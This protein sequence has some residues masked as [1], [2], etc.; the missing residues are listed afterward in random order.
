MRSSLDDIADELFHGGKAKPEPLGEKKTRGEK[1]EKGESQGK[2][3]DYRKNPGANE[4]RKRANSPLEWAKGE[5]SPPAYPIEALGPLAGVAHVIAEKGQI[6]PAMAGQCVLTAA[7][8]CVQGLKEVR[9]L[10]GSKPLSLY[11]ATI[12]DSGD[13]KSFAEGIALGGIRKLE[14]K[15]HL[16]YKASVEKDMKGKGSK[17]AASG[18]ELPP[19]YILMKNATAQGIWRSFRDG[20]ASQGSFT[21]E[22]AV[23]L[24]GWGM[25]AEQ[26]AHTAGSVNDLWDGGAISIQRG[27]EGRTQ[28]YG[29]RFTVH[30]LIQPD[31]VSESLH[32]PLL[33]TIGFWPRF[34]IAW[35]SPMKP[36]TAASW[37]FWDDP[38]VKAFW[39]RCEAL[40]EPQM[41][42]PDEE[43]EFP[44]IACENEAYKL[45]CAFFERMEQQARGDG[46]KLTEI[47]SFA[48]RA[49]EQAFRI[50]GVLAVFNGDDE[51]RIEAMRSGIALAAYSLDTWRGIFGDREENE[52]RLWAKQLYTWIRDKSDGTATETAMLKCA[53]PK[54]LRSKHKRDTAMGILQ[55]EGLLFPALEFTANGGDR[56][57]PHTWRTVDA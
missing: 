50:A 3:S 52:H 41:D 30:W 13:G 55:A 45:A 9:T 6:D 46:G 28:L 39:H 19:P 56:A 42:W 34:L 31:A 20:V 57:V 25:S 51:I 8:L 38:T 26:R 48:V 33:T 53:T 54:S 24:S 40:L 11:G 35:P 15:N 16:I 21:S 47:K 23:M 14:H 12:A 27:T 17:E 7:A 49:T 5:F 29:R 43:R 36:R 2:S 37:H 10:A 32:D 22:A 44:H 4:G 18:E 1:G